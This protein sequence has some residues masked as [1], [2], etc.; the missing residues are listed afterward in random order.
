MF[1]NTHLKSVRALR[2]TVALSLVVAAISGALTVYLIRQSSQANK[3]LSQIDSATTTSVSLYAQGLQMG[4]ATRNIL[5]DPTNPIAYKNHAAA[6]K[7]FNDTL[8][9]LD[10][11][12]QELFPDSEAGR[13]LASIQQDF[14]AHL[15]VQQKINQL[16]RSGRL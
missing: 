15:V 1:K 8:E 16:A 4:Q 6:A 10:K 14:R 9:Q 11:Q 3:R 5:L 7:D 13:T 12:L 2:Y